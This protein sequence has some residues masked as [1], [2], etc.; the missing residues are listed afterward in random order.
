M[1]P[2]S[3]TTWLVVADGATAQIYAVHAIP[4]RLSP[5]PA[6]T[7][8]ASRKLARQPEHRP[9]TLHATH[10]GN[11]HGAQ[12]RQ[13][14]VFVEHV[15]ETLDAAARDG[16]Y[17]DIIVVLPPKALAHFRKMAGPEVQNR[18]KQEIPGE[19]THLAMPDLKRHLAAVL[20]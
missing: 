6:G 2:L 7:L 11:G 1:P 13:E 14:H 15:V 8:K 17:D 5:V 9:D 18:I 4:L 16:E 19:W 10:V 3:K 20:P 12:E